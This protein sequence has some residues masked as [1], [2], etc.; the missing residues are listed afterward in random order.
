MFT[1]S[2]DKLNADPIDT[3]KPLFNLFVTVSSHQVFD[4][5]P[6]DAAYKKTLKIVSQLSDDKRK[7]EEKRINVSTLFVYLDMCLQQFFNDYKKRADFDN[8]IF[9]ITGDHA[10]GLK[11]QNDLSAFHVPLLIWSPMLTKSQKFESVVSHNDIAPTVCALLKQNFLMQMPEHVHWIGDQLNNNIDFQSKQKTMLVNYGVG[12]VKFIY[13]N[14]YFDGS[15]YEINDNLSPSALTNDSLKNLLQHK[16]DIFKYIHRYV[17]FN[18][19]L[20][21]NAPKENGKYETVFDEI[22]DS[23][24]MEFLIN[25]KHGKVILIPQTIIN[26]SEKA[27]NEVKVTITADVQFHKIPTD[28]HE[29]IEFHLVCRG[30]GVKNPNNYG[31]VVCKYLLSND[32]IVNEWNKFELSKTFNIKNAT[33]AKIRA[34]I[35]K[36]RGDETQS[37]LWRNIRIKIEVRKKRD[38]GK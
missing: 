36:I 2:F 23:I 33:S 21:R 32:I 26:N 4:N 19:K 18:D 34:Y 35:H 14:Y 11:Q 6:F 29:F 20:T 9:I 3:N 25:G 16:F 38:K 24:K 31:D 37:S 28:L 12:P 17:Y 1:K 15:L 22:I 5:N 27:I 10:S 7:K 30:N 8:T 13:N